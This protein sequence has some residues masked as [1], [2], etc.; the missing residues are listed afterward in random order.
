MTRAIGSRRGR[1]RGNTRRTTIAVGI[2]AALV[3]AVA[4]YVGGTA[5]SGLPFVPTYDVTVAVP[6]ADHLVPTDE[7][8]IDGVRVGQVS[9]VS[10]ERSESGTTFARI[11]LALEDSLHHLPIDTQVKV[12]AASVL[13]ATYVDLVPGS[14]PATVPPGGHIGLANAQPTVELVD[15]LDVFD[16]ATAAAV[17]STLD[18]AGAGVA[19]RGPALNL[20]IGAVNALLPALTH[21]ETLLADPA[22][23][24]P[25]FLSAYERTA[26]AMAPVAG[27]FAR[28]LANAGTTFD[29]LDRFPPAL[30]A[31]IDALPG[32]AD[33]V[34]T[35]WTLASPALADLA[36]LV[37][38][39]RPAGAAL[40]S[41]LSAAEMALRTG[42]PA[43]AQVPPFALRLSDALAEVGT[44]ASHPSTPGALRKLTDTVTAVTPTIDTLMPAQVDCNAMALM[45]IRFGKIFSL[46]GGGA[47]SM[48]TASLGLGA[49]GSTFQRATPSPNLGVNYLP[50]ETASECESGNEPG[51][52]LHG[53]PSLSNPPGD[54]SRSV[55]STAPPPGVMARAAQAG[56]LD[57]VVGLR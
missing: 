9:S 34:R 41:T 14:S 6:N 40:P 32:T 37:T 24:L 38:R 7:V 45:W 48:V 10:A 47:Q 55:P 31:T 49:S 43:L 15:L 18:D 35:G 17:R 25:A 12:R 54:Q 42:T 51:P 44:V 56:L 26:Q 53:P 46:G 28:L 39:L 19:G 30:G 52:P 16:H 13:G 2:V 50:H 36:T 57:K 20:T 27:R 8:R 33:A 21:V 3:L 5:I 11:G 22:T 1:R 29:A 23:R 4:S